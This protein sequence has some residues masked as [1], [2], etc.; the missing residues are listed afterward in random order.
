MSDRS[1]AIQP[2]G[3]RA[4]FP[5][6]TVVF[7]IGMRVNSL[8][9]VRS[10]LPVFRAMPRMLEELVRQPELGLLHARTELAW[11]RA[12]VIQ[13]WQSMDKLMAYSAARDRTHL[14][15]W[16]AYNASVNRSGPVVGV[17]HEAYEVHPMIAHTVY[18]NMPRFGMAAATHGA[19]VGHVPDQTDR[20][21]AEA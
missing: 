7:L 21:A 2:G 17:W 6:G 14:P 19:L 12:T 20:R 15:A 10:W 5:D 16:R 8:W 11:R 1:N 4:E 3:Y 9:R 18:R 13:Y